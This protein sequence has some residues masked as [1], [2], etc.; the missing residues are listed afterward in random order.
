MALTDVIQNQ[1]IV[2]VSTASQI[3]VNGNLVGV[4]QT[5]TP[6]Q[7]RASTPVRG[8]GI[9][10]RI[11]ERVWQLTDYKISVNKMALF[12]KKMLN[13]FGYGNTF[14]MLAQLRVPI[15]I[16]EI[17][18]LPDG[19]NVYTTV[20]RG[21]Y[22]NNYSDPK[23]ITGEIIVTE[24]ADFDCTSIDDGVNSPFDYDVGINP[25]SNS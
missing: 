12:S 6:S 14:R 13:L 11:I 22:M 16:Q 8:I 5:I 18:L 15:D 4:I 25:P 21:C 17:L 20:Y 1:Q 2:A 7:T 10:D 23:T 19:T 24:T 3:L 9:G